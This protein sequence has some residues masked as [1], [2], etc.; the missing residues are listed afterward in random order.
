M[1]KLKKIFDKL[2]TFYEKIFDKIE[3]RGGWESI[4]LAG[5][6]I[7]GRLLISLRKKG[8]NGETIDED[9][10]EEFLSEIDTKITKFIHEFNPI[11]N[12]DTVSE[13]ELQEFAIAKVKELFYLAIDNDFDTK[14][15]FQHIIDSLAEDFKLTPEQVKGLKVFVIE[16]Y[17]QRKIAEN[18]YTEFIGSIDNLV[19]LI[20]GKKLSELTGV[21]VKR[22][23]FG[24]EFYMS[25]EAYK[26]Y[27]DD[28]SFGISRS[29]KNIFHVISNRIGGL[30]NLIFINDEKSN[31][32]G[33]VR[34]ERQHARY[35]FENTNIPDKS[36]KEFNE[37]FKRIRDEEKK[38]IEYK[39][40]KQLLSDYSESLMLF[41][42]TLFNDLF[43]NELLAQIT[44]R[45]IIIRKKTLENTSERINLNSNLNEIL[46]E[47][48]E[49][50]R[51]QLEEDLI[52]SIQMLEEVVTA[53]DY[54]KGLSNILALSMERSYKK[55][56][57]NEY[58]IKLEGLL[59]Y[60]DYKKNI[61]EIC[62]LIRDLILKYPDD[63]E[64]LVRY[65]SQFSL[66]E[67]KQKL[68]LYQAIKEKKN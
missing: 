15:V 38:G 24:L 30:T 66:E 47:S 55:L 5:N 8:L 64:F 41:F 46:N 17:I 50:I 9:K 22:G 20:T 49:R 60:E 3:S 26:K 53:Y 2:D 59:V 56:G 58:S 10:E 19:L 7:L 39:D 27:F 62:R 32:E 31:G 13:E 48:R 16:Y 57:L 14:K 11:R 54:R 52:E 36:T 37:R 1:E 33:T 12:E 35:S 63:K 29:Y 25:S 51:H 45:R 6:Q 18:T 21:K 65:F 61:V 34:H 68:Y 23:K 67:W 28:N 4:E 44:G 42:N 40:K 43:K